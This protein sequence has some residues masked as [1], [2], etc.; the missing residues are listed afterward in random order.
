VGRSA[1]LFGLLGLLLL[2]FGFVATAFVE[3]P[4]SDPFVLVN[5]ILGA[6]LLLLTLV[7][8][9]DNLR[10]LIGQRSTRYGA[11]AALYSLLVVALLVGLSYLGVRHHHRWDVT[12]SGAYTLSPQSQKVIGSL[13]DKLVITAFAEGGQNPQVETLLDGYRYASPSQVETRIV[14]P[15]KEPSLAEEMKIT[16]VPSVHLQYGKESF[17]VTQPTEE[18]ITNGIIRVTRS[19]KKVVYFT[20]GFGE[21]GFQNADDPKGYSEAKLALEQENYEIKPLL[22][23]SLEQI[24]D[25][26]SVVILDGPNRPL[27]DAAIA[28]LDTY[29]KRG[30]HLLA[31]IGPQTSSDKVGEKLTALLA[32]WGVKLGGDIVIDREVRLFEGPRLGVV[33]LSRTYGTHPIT[34]GFKDF[35]VY[36]QTRSV[37][38]AA[39][40]KKGLQATTL[41]KTSESSW[42]ET[43]VDGVINKGVATLDQT[44]KKGPVSIAVA[45]TANLKDLGVSPPEGITDARLV[46]FGSMLFADNQQLEQSR[47][48]G[49]LFLN[50][51]GWLVG[52]E[53]LVS[54]RSQ[55]VRASRAD[56]TPKQAAQVFYLSV[57]IIPELLIALGIWVWWRRRAA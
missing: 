37:E 17:V 16:T 46:V 20:E 29:L 56:L 19:G 22:L 50:A 24:P 9:L 28:A 26:A 40:G 44:D 41:V 52:Q 1:S 54:I 11:S 45:V 30:G 21:P 23:P 33:P 4:A 27:T 39:E 25:D 43:D 51:V 57:F 36:P 34:Q 12:E 35:T 42:A 13:K 47:L 18:T 53:E 3:F 32:Q 48:N 14:D 49:D 15:D 6:G 8:G 31:M 10:G 2:A 7:F 5:V 38:P 55:S